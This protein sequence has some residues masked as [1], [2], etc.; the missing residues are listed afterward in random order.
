MFAGVGAGVGT[1]VESL[2]GGP[3]ILEPYIGVLATGCAC[4][5]IILFMLGCD[6]EV[7]AVGR[8]EERKTD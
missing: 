5:F 8:S 1:G 7:A 2:G 3:A 4:G 6:E